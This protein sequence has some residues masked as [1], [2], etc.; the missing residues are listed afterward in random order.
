MLETIVIHLEYEKHSS[1]SAFLNYWNKIKR[2]ILLDKKQTV[3]FVMN[4]PI[5]NFSVAFVPQLYLEQEERFDKIKKIMRAHISSLSS[6]KAFDNINF[7][8]KFVVTRGNDE[9]YILLNFAKNV[10]SELLII[11]NE[12]KYT[13]KV[14]DY[15]FGG[16]KL[17]KY[18]LKNS[19]C[20]VM[21]IKN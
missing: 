21:L 17:S 1:S 5:F 10:K 12:K 14:L 2:V 7:K 19:P 8:L 15:F 13:N 18:I 9:S 4:A 11:E 16:N 3:Y 20:S 6:Y